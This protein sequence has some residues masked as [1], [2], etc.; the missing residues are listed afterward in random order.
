MH[1]DTYKQ[2]REQGYL[3]PHAF[4]NHWVK[5]NYLHDE[6]VGTKY[7]E[8]GPNKIEQAAKQYWDQIKKD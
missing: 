6:L 3:Y 1:Y 8:Y 7:Y 4:P 2:E 5:Q